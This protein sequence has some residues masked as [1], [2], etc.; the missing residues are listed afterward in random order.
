[1]LLKTGGRPARSW[2]IGKKGSTRGDPV[3][4]RREN[5]QAMWVPKDLNSVYSTLPADLFR[6]RQCMAAS[7]TFR[8]LASEK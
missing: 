7:L 3:E 4:E 1:M 2:G 8:M 5:W 6:G